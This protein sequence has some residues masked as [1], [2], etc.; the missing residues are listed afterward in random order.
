MKALEAINRP[1]NHWDDLLIHLIG[2]KFDNQ[3]AVASEN[4]LSTNSPTIKDHTDFLTQ[5]CQTLESLEINS[6]YAVCWNFLQP[7]LEHPLCRRGGDV[8]NQKN[9]EDRTTQDSTIVS[10]IQTHYLLI[11]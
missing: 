10:S 4:T 1:V 8:Q 6:N 3:T 11:F 7:L 9:L 2:Q 5:G